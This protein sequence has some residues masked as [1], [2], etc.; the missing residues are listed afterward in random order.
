MF[1]YSMRDMREGYRT[2]WLHGGYVC[3]G[4]CLCTGY[5]YSMRD[6]YRAGWLQGGMFVAYVCVQYERWL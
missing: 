6:G 4:V 1:V 5:M 2:G 3:G